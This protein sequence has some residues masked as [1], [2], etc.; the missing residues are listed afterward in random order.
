MGYYAV[1][2]VNYKNGKFYGMRVIDTTDLFDQSKTSVKFMDWSASDLLVRS[3]NGVMQVENL[4]MSDG[5]LAGRHGKLSRYPIVGEQYNEDGSKAAI[6]VMVKTPDKKFI[7]V[8]S[9]GNKAI[10]TEKQLVEYGSLSNA[11]I[12][13]GHVA[14]LYHEI[15]VAGN[16]TS[17]K[18]AVAQSDKDRFNQLVKTTQNKLKSMVFDAPF[19]KPENMVHTWKVICKPLVEQYL[20]LAKSKAQATQASG[21]T[22]ADLDKFMDFQVNTL[23]MDKV[24]PNEKLA[25][26]WRYNNTTKGIEYGHDGETGDMIGF[27]PRA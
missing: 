16:V 12:V 15:P 19:A 13:D 8:D 27:D 14:G 4:G 10:M 3:I 7:A 23:K 17:A 21:M 22:Q 24:Y 25:Q 18:S 1:A 2:K 26:L 9:N 11:K 5:Q 20:S 6:T